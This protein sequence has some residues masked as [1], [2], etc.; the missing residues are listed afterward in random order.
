MKYLFKERHLSIPIKNPD[1]YNK[2]YQTTSRAEGGD[3][4]PDKINSIMLR[5]NKR[6]LRK[7]EQNKEDDINMKLQQA[8]ENWNYWKFQLNLNKIEWVYQG[9][10]YLKN[11][12]F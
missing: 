12:P 1:F 9:N 4:F 7:K 11:N 10:K 6:W 2:Y 3:L 5:I 8:N